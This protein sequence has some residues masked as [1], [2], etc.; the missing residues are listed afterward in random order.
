MR[1]HVHQTFSIS[2]PLG[3]QTEWDNIFFIFLFFPEAEW[4]GLAHLQCSL[5]P[6][7]GSQIRALN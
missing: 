6:F 3:K 2:I 5:K 1:L 7:P 4:I